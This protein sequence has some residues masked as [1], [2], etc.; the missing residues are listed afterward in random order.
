MVSKDNN[1]TSDQQPVVSDRRARRKLKR[2]EE[3]VRAKPGELVNDAAEDFDEEDYEDDFDD[4][5]DAPTGAAVTA[6]KGKPT[7]SRE[8]AIKARQAAL[9]GR[10]ERTP[11]LGGIVAYFQ[12]V[13]AEVQKVTWPTSEEAFRMTR[14]VLSVTVAFSIVLGAIDLF[15]GW[16]FQQGIDDTAIFLIVGAIVAV[17]AGAG[18][19]FLVIKEPQI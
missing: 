14:L 3:V 17:I 11:V 7:L 10:A 13:I 5:D 15:Y 6:P 4:E 8:D 9:Q 2:G 19:Y 16:W 18:A 12:G 1:K